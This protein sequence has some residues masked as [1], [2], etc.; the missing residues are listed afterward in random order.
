M[1]LK[2]KNT[3]KEKMINHIKKEIGNLISVKPAVSPIDEKGM[4]KELDSSEIFNNARVENFTELGH[5]V[6]VK[7]KDNYVNGKVV[8]IP[9]GYKSKNAIVKLENGTSI[10]VNVDNAFD[11]VRRGTIETQAV[12]QP[13]GIPKELEKPI[14]KKSANWKELKDLRDEAKL[15]KKI[16]GDNGMEKFADQVFTKW[17]IID[18][19]IK[20]SLS[21]GAGFSYFGETSKYK[22]GLNFSDKN[23]LKKFYNEAVKQPAVKGVILKDTREEIEVE[24]IEQMTIRE[25]RFYT[26]LI[27]N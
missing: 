10:K 6:I 8:S 25:F 21:E 1:I 7:I 12:K 24:E 18:E 19:S 27:N 14:W 20:K 22:F 16:Y 11:K 3:G 9:Q 5:S 13:A 26:A 23:E 17:N 4:P 15:M 2:L